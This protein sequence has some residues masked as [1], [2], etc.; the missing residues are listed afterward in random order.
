MALFLSPAMANQGLLYCDGSLSCITFRNLLILFSILVNPLSNSFSHTALFSFSLSKAINLKFQQLLSLLPTS[1]LTILSTD[2]FQ[3]HSL[4][5]AL[6]ISTTTR[7]F[8]R[9]SSLT[10]L[11]SSF[12]QPSTDKLD[13][14]SYL[15]TACTCD[16][17][18]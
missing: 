14:P 6:H 10:F 13:Q 18:L 2:P 8:T 3:V 1:K 9:S 4:L 15:N 11:A 16:R 7:F 17:C 12:R 5:T